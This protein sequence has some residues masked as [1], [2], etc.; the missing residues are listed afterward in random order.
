MKGNT[1]TE[2]LSI[3]GLQEIMIEKNG[4]EAFDRE[5]FD[6][7][8]PRDYFSSSR[9]EM[10]DVYRMS[11]LVLLHKASGLRLEYLITESY[12]GDE[13]R[14]RFRSMFIITSSGKK[15]DVAEVNFEKEIF[16]TPDVEVSFS[17]VKVNSKG[18]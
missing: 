16:T 10:D 8:T 6:S 14:Y 15:L 13:Y 9:K 17:E 11:E 18:D 2:I 4:M 12:F 7:Y 1:L 5:L 3:L